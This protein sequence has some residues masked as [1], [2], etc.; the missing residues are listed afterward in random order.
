MQSKE[1]KENVLMGPIYT[2]PLLEP[3]LF[4]KH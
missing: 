4:P 1:T 2:T 3:V